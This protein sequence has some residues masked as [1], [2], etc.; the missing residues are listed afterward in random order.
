MR[1]RLWAWWSVGFVRLLHARGLFAGLYR[2]EGD[3]ESRE[4]VECY[5]LYR[6]LTVVIIHLAAREIF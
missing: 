2:M 1:S 5:L 4:L 3:F 6:G